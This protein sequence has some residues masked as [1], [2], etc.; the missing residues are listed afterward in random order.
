MPEPEASAVDSASEPSDQR[1]T[2]AEEDSFHAAAA[3]DEQSSSEPGTASDDH[4]R[5]EIAAEASEEPVPE[6]EPDTGRPEEDEANQSGVAGHDE[7]DVVSTITMADLY[8]RQG[9]VDQAREIYRSILEREPG[10][11]EAR[12]RLD[13]LPEEGRGPDDGDAGPSLSQGAKVRR[14]EDW[15]GKVRR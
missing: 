2:G 7:D 5:E 4:A 1:D 9:H 14:L 13:S 6:S 10:H 15:L 8:A 12:E 3:A 11:G